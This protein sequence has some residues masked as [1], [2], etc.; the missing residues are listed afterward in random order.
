[1]KEILTALQGGIE[2][3]GSNFDYA[4]PLTEIVILGTIAMRSN[5]KVEYS[6]ENMTIKDASLS[7]Y[8]KDPVRQGWEYG[9][10]I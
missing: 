1:M 10:N 9:E 7:K 8:I 2:K 5:K 4:V 3:P 6:P